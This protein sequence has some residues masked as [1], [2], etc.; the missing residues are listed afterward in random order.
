MS[1]REKMSLD[2]LQ[3]QQSDPIN[4]AILD[5]FF[6]VDAPQ[7]LGSSLVLTK[8][9]K[10]L[11]VLEMANVDRTIVMSYL[12]NMAKDTKQMSDSLALMKQAYQVNKSKYQGKYDE[13]A[14]MYS[15]SISHEMQEWL[16]QYENTIG[17][18]IE[19]IT[20]YINSVEPNNPITNK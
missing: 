11:N 5:N 10:E 16:E 13:N 6:N 18:S 2:Y 9:I 3:P 7:A 1:N 15:L 4:W 8:T 14:H 19:D 17:Q 20:N 12:S